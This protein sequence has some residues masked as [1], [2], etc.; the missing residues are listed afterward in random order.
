MKILYIYSSTNIPTNQPLPLS[1]PNLYS[2]INTVVSIEE[3]FGPQ[4]E[5]EFELEFEFEF[6][7]FFL[8]IQKQPN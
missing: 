4:F 3:K 2:Y 5:F 6:D 7:I 8:F 1:P